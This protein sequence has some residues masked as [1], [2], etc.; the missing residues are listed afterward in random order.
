MAEL[1][2]L[3]KA[4]PGKLDFANSGRGAAAYLSAMLFNKEAGLDIVAIDY[5]GSAPGLQDVIAGEVDMMF[6]TSASV[7][8]HIRAGTLRAL[9]VTTPAAIARGP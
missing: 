7:I 6:A 4:Q 3:A 2:K 9:A 5:K 8:G 1:V